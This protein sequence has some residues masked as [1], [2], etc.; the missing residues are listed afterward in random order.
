MQKEGKSEAW[1]DVLDLPLAGTLWREPTK[2]SVCL[3]GF[4]ACVPFRMRVADTTRIGPALL[5]QVTA[6]ILKLQMDSN[7]ARKMSWRSERAAAKTC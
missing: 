5:V 2:N 6:S 1:K 7:S 4:P 3:F